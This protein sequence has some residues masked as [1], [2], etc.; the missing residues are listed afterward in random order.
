M[1]LEEIGHFKSKI[2]LSIR[3]L[4]YNSFSLKQNSALD[5]AWDNQ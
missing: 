2:G 3:L 4:G 5:Y 1:S